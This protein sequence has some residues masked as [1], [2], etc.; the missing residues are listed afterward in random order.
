MLCLLIS[1]HLA[2][3][4]LPPLLIP[5]PILSGY[6]ILEQEGLTGLTTFLL[7]EIRRHQATLLIIDGAITAK[8]AAKSI[9]EW[10]KF[11]H[12]IHVAAEIN[13]CTTFLLMPVQE[14]SSD[15]PEQTMVDGLIALTARTVEMRTMRELQVLKIR[16]S[17]FVEGHH[18][19]AI[20][21][22]GFVVHPR[23]EAMLTITAND[24]PTSLTTLEQPALL[25][26]GIAHLDEMLHGGLPS[27]STTLLLGTSGTGKTLLG[28][29]FLVEGA[30]Q[31]QK[32]LYFGFNETP[33]QLLRTMTRFGLDANQLCRTGLD[34][35]ALA[36]S[37][38]G[39]P[40][41][42]GRTLTGSMR[43]PGDTATLS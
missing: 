27:G 42:P 6:A 20:T 33:A 38:P 4:R 23:T 11:L 22:N 43:T 29:H 35:T 30:I 21:G 12:N 8:Q 17:Q 31:G 36:S 1:N 28:N 7:K 10:A 37:Y 25:R 16:G 15:Q 5:F 14:N 9:H 34:R 39:L 24:L 41:Y 40:R 3:F 19:Y 13:R 2:F 32:G 26:T 18:S